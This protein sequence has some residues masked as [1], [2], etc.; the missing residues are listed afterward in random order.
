LTSQ[1]KRQ[2]PTD[3]SVIDSAS[4]V[5][6]SGEYELTAEGLISYIGELTDAL[7]EAEA[8]IER[9]EA[10][11]TVDDVK[12]QI[13]KPYVTNVFR[14]VVC[15]CAI[16]GLMLTLAGFKTGGFVLPEAI[17]GIIAGSTAV[18]VI[19]LIGMVI[20]GLFGKSGN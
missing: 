3:P 12:A 16:V 13:L 4:T 2:G 7:G 8:E 5:I 9:L 19:G 20:T 18:S 1:K 15:Y 11:S 17:L 10:K 14:F 6:A